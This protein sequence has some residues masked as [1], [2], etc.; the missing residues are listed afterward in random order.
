MQDWPLTTMKIL[1]Y[2]AQWHPEQ[3]IVTKTVEGPIT[4]TTYADLKRRSQ[5]CCLALRALGM[6]EGACIATLAWN[7][8]RHMEAWYG[9]MGLGGVVHTLNPRLSD[10]DI[11]YIMQDA[12][13]CLLLADV[14]FVAQ[15]ARILPNVPSVQG[16]IFMTD[17]EHMPVGHGLGVPVHCYEDLVGGQAMALR[18]LSAAG[19][20]VWSDVH[21]DAACGLCYTSGTTGNPK[22]VLYSHR[23]QFLHALLLVQPDS[24]PLSS[25]ST[26]LA[27]VPMFHANVW[28]LVFAAPMVGARLVMPGPWLDGES[29]YNLC[30]QFRVTVSAGVPTVWLALLTYMEAHGLKGFDTFRMA[31]IGGAAAPRSMIDAFERTHGVEVRHLWG[32]T[33]L[34]PLG[35]LGGTK[36]PLLARPE[37]ERTAAKL[38]QGRPHV[39]C[40]MRIVDDE[41]R[42]LPHDGKAVGHLHVRGPAVVAQYLNTDKRAVDGEGWFATG[43]VASIDKLG[44]MQIT[45]RSKDVIKSGGE[46]ISSIEI[47][48]LAMGH[49]HVAEAAVV[50]IND[51]RWGERPLLVVVL[52]PGHE[53]EAEYHERVRDELYKYLVPRLAKFAVPDDIVFVGEIPHNATGKVSKLTLRDMFKHHKPART[54]L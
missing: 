22:G 30:Q 40:E 1:D 39:L 13:D 5:L 20:S 14:T 34:T 11:A 21:E 52:K 41:G 28:G 16:V 32:M 15:L 18:E 12:E 54:R 23:A 17:R 45:D 36:A 42:V 8:V 37:G 48:N 7:G 47:E 46:W 35:T 10:K 3:E 26:C 44:H 51:E 31:V 19:G 50:A 29:I 49:P 33:E 43:D 53:A 4:I 24:V 9:I 2:A 25:S 38:K 27:I 6:G